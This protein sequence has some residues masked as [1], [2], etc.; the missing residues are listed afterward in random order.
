MEAQGYSER[1]G[2]SF[3]HEC[4]YYSLA[5]AR[6][7]FKKYWTGPVRPIRLFVNLALKS[8]LIALTARK[9]HIASTPN[10]SRLSRRI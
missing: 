5:E 6:K 4:K 1:Y 10:V 9:K 2:E 7:Y 8:D 3:Q